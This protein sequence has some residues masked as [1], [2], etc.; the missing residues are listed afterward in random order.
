[1]DWQLVGPA[2]MAAQ[3]GIAKETF[4]SPLLVFSHPPM[5]MTSDGAAARSTGSAA[6]TALG[7]QQL[8]SS[9]CNPGSSAT[10][11]TAV[12]SSSPLRVGSRQA[13]F[14]AGNQ[15]IS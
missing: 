13:E 12:A 14:G 7:M 6:A 5:R 9:A 8:T 4:G 1:M 11:A 15:A 10:A 3:Y 2:E